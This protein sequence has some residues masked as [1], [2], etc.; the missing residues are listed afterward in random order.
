MVKMQMWCNAWHN[1]TQKI[2]KKLINFEK[3]Q[4]PKSKWMKCMI[5]REKRYHTRGRKQTLGWKTGGEGEEVEWEMFER[6]KRVFL[7]SEIE[8]KWEKNRT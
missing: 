1:P 8:E 7:S 6:E 2:H 3:P 5:K 4:K